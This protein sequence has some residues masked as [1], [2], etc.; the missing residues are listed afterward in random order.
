MKFSSFLLTLFDLLILVSG[1]KVDA[2][3]GIGN[4]ETL[5][6]TS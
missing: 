1:V 3:L 6:A 4:D 2:S 5:C